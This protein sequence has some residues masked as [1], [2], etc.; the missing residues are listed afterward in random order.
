[1][2][3]NLDEWVVESFLVKR[4]SRNC[5]GE[6]EYLS[7]CKLNISDNLKTKFQEIIKKYLCDDESGFNLDLNS[8]HEYMSDDSKVKNYKI[9]KE[10]LT[11]Q[12]N[13][14]NDLLSKIEAEEGETAVATADYS[15]YSYIVLKIFK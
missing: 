4:D 7:V 12:N 14:F 15:K 13:Y 8:F 2:E 10:E 9:K 3:L 5:V 1:M 11:E 6:E